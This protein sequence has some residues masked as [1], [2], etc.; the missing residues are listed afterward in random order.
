VEKV[1]SFVDTPDGYKPTGAY[2]IIRADNH[3]VLAGAVGARYVAPPHRDLFNM[4][5]EIL[6]AQ[7]PDLKIA[8]VGTLSGGATWWVQLVAKEYYIRGDE[9]PNEVRI[10]FSHTY[11]VTSYKIH[12]TIVR[13]VCDNTKRMAE[14]DALAKK[15]MRSHKHTASAQVKINADLDLMVQVQLGLKKEVEQME[16]LASQPVNSELIKAFMGEFIPEPLP[17]AS[18]KAKNTY[19][20]SRARVANIF[21]TGQ[22]LIGD[23]KTSRYALLN[24]FTDFID[25]DSYSRDPAD[26]WMD[27]IDGTRAATKDQAVAWLLTK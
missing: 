2:S 11:G 26:R 24:A 16:Y 10:T 13:I 1:P 17:D 27:S 6:L 8:G 20:N 7:Y 22:S 21:Q 23:V 5:V 3:K 4:M 14:S 15:F 25:H 9:S 18:T 12:P 19:M